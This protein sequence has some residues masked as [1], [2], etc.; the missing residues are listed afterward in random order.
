MPCRPRARIS[1]VP[2]GA[3]AQRIEVSAEADDPDQEQAPRAEQVAERAAD[4]EERAERQQVGV[5]DPLLQREP[6]AEVALDRGQRD[7]HDRRVDEDDDGAEDARDQNE[8]VAIRRR[9]TVGRQCA[10]NVPGAPAIPHG[11]WRVAIGGSLG[12]R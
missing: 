2:S 6:A 5:D 10:Q 4:Q 9:L 11:W 3:A 1:V 12:V 7:V 8:T